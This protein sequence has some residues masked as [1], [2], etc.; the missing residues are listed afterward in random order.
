MALSAEKN[1]F[2]RL[3][4]PAD[5]AHEAAVVREVNV[6]S[7]YALP[8]VLHLLNGGAAEYLAG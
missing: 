5:N 7:A 4:L 1:K 2:R 6:Y 3:L 8:Q